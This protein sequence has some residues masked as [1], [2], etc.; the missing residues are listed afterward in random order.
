[1]SGM[2]YEQEEHFRNKIEEKYRLA[3]ELRINL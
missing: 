3:S 1:M 2:E